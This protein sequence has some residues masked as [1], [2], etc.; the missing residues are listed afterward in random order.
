[1]LG[2]DSHSAPSKTSSNTASGSIA[3]HRRWWACPGPECHQVVP[4]LVRIRYS[5]GL[6][7]REPEWLCSGCLEALRELEDSYARGGAFAV[8]EMIWGIQLLDAKGEAA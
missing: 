3:Q 2:P 5:V 6:E 8:S 1:M 4:G 7:D